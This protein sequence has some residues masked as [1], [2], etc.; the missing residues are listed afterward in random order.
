ML[1][2]ASLGK[3]LQFDLIQR[4]VENLRDCLSLEFAK[5]RQSNHTLQGR[6][7]ELPSHPFAK[8][9]FRVIVTHLVI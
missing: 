9:K 4:S 3:Q 6:K 8:T 2:R 1:T 5:T 7:E